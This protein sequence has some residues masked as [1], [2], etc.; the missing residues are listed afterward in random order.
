MLHLHALS[1]LPIF[2]HKMMGCAGTQ[3]DL[4]VSIRSRD[5][6]GPSFGLPPRWI[7]VKVEPN[8]GQRAAPCAHVSA[9]PMKKPPLGF[10]NLR[11]TLDFVCMVRYQARPLR[12]SA[13]VCS[14]FF[15][16]IFLPAKSRNSVWNK[17]NVRPRLF[18]F[19]LPAVKLRFVTTRTPVAR[20][21]WK[22][23]KIG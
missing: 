23:P 1:T 18:A 22:L 16:T 13:F 6:F 21:S 14:I 4:P 8:V 20:M 3:K 9:G 5:L 12:K 11:R 10:P 7:R 19:S 2:D 15:S 17:I